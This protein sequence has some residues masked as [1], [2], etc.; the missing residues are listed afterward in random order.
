MCDV[1]LF[2]SSVDRDNQRTWSHPNCV[3]IVLHPGLV[4]EGLKVF[5]GPE[6]E[7]LTLANPNVLR[8]ISRLVSKSAAEPD[9]TTQETRGEFKDIPALNTI[10]PRG[11]GAAAVAVTVA[12]CAFAVAVFRNAVTP[13]TS[14]VPQ[15]ASVE[16][17]DSP[18]ALDDLHLTIHL[19]VDPNQESHITEVLANGTHLETKG[20][21]NSGSE[22]ADEA[23]EGIP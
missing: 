19:V 23:T 21:D 18:T 5:R 13:V 15:S 7:Q 8:R 11:N 16:M 22:S 9:A 4:G 3:G 12:I 14:P 6:S 2:Y 17:S 20:Q 10:H 1:G